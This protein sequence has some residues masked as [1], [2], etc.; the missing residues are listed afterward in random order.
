MSARLSVA[1]IDGLKNVDLARDIEI[2]HAPPEAGFERQLACLGEGSRGEQKEVDIAKRLVK[3]PMIFE[4]KSAVLKAAV[5]RERSDGL[6]IA[7]GE[8]GPQPAPHGFIDDQPACVPIRTIN[9]DSVAHTP[10]DHYSGERRLFKGA[11]TISDGEE[12]G[13]HAM[14]LSW[15]DF[16]GLRV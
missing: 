3:Q 7:P 16:F 13:E 8:D 2:V 9:E 10:P 1:A 11:R 5:F 12:A 6:M 15:R 14:R 4:P